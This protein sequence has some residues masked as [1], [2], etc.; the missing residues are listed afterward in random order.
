M[1]KLDV[2]YFF[3]FAFIFFNFSIVFRIY[4]DN[5]FVPREM[6]FNNLQEFFIRHEVQKWPLFN[7]LLFICPPYAIPALYYA[8]RYFFFSI[9]IVYKYFLEHEDS[10]FKSQERGFP[11]FKNFL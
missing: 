9:C 1:G 10:N 5:S 3:I 4:A 8:L 6:L 2:C 11:P 7:I